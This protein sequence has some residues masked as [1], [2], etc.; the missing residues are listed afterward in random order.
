MYVCMYTYYIYIYIYT[1][2]VYNYISV[3]DIWENEIGH[4]KT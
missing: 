2:I 3:P 4:G 1:H